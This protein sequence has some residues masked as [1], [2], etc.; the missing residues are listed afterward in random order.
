MP[1]S[2]HAFPFDFT[3]TALAGSSPTSTTARPGR[4]PSETSFAVPTATSSRSS[5][6]IAFPSS[7]SAGK[8]H[9]SRLAYQ[10][11]LDLP[12][13]LQLR[14]DPPRDLLRH[15]PHAHVVP[16]VGGYDHANLAAGLDGEHLL[17]S[18]VARRDLLQ[19]LEP[20]HISLERFA[21]RAGARAGD[22]V[23]RLHQHRDLALVRHVVVVRG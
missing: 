16:V 18:L 10:H 21:P 19:P 8:V 15:R 13:V 4:T 6:A 11:D 1:A 5:R 7:S 20:L 23:R 2:S 9:R 17:H 3:Y 12:R 14:L 22:R